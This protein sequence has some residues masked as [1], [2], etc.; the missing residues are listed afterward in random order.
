MVKPLAA[1]QKSHFY[2]GRRAPAR[3]VAA[4]GANPM[5][6]QNW[7]GQFSPENPIF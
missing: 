6:P 7:M 4:A 1:S 5:L 2:H 3:D